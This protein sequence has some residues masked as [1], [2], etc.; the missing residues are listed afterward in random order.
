M[1]SH[2]TGSTLIEVL[3]AMV[4][5]AIGLI[6]MAGLQATSVQSNQGAYYRS[7]ASIL[8]NDM[9]DRIRANRANA[10][11]GAYTMSSF[12]DSSTSN[13]VTGSR[14][15]ID[16]GEWLNQLASTLPDGTGMVALNGNVF[17]ISIRWNDNRARIKASNDTSSTTETFQYRTRL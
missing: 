8:A 14:A 2:Q 5:L 9:A 13:S 11:S 10:L 6:G 1:P 15:A 3:I 4:V 7:Q 17:T 16:R 12:P